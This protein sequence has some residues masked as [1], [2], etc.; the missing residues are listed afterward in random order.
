LRDR[1]ILVR[2]L[3]ILV[4]ARRINVVQLVVHMSQLGAYKKPHIGALLKK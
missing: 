3:G 4:R 2:D 1:A